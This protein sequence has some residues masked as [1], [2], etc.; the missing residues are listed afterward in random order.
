M[1]ISLWVISS[2]SD[3]RLTTGHKGRVHI[4]AVLYDNT[5]NTIQYLQ[6]GRTDVSLVLGQWADTSNSHKK[7]FHR[8]FVWTPEILHQW[9][10]T[11]RQFWPYCDFLFFHWDK[12]V[13]VAFPIH[14]QTKCSTAGV[15]GHRSN[16]KKETWNH[17]ERVREKTAQDGKHTCACYT[18]TWEIRVSVTV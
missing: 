12:S 3:F 7:S 10:H 1:G 6:L 17:W 16:K 18:K 13:C 8:L 4:H 5:S 2:T 15:Y 9:P 11:T 14:H